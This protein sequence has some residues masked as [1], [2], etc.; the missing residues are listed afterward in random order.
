VKIRHKHLI[1]IADIE[2]SSGC[3]DYEMSSFM[4]RSWPEAC[5]AMSLDVDVLVNT[6]FDAGAESIIV[7]DFH[8]TGFNL[9]PELINSKARVVQGYQIGPV[10]G[11]GD[12]SPATGLIM[13]G[14]HA[15]SG[16]SGFLAHTL[17]S[18]ICRL[19]V[20]GELMSEAELFSASLAPWG[21]SPLFFS[22]CP[23]ACQHVL[24]KIPGIQCY[25]VDKTCDRSSLDT[26]NWRRS[27]AKTAADS[28]ENEN[29]TPF[30]P[31]GPFKA[32]VEMR[33]GKETAQRLAERWNYP[34]SES[35]ITLEAPDIHTLYQQLM[36]LCYLSPL[37]QKILPLGLSLFNLRGR[38][39]LAWVRSQLQKQNL[40]TG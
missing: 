15:P 25:P 16:S 32:I 8:R 2:G 7:K 21:L 38:F 17:T 9:L 24:R 13:V 1:I 34:V 20:N 11:I 12:P 33:D 4:T 14:M 10:P 3:R 23:V 28:L 5:H 30:L 19:E 39:G 40:F 6:L 22:G 29:S 27:M 18:R 31:E 37:I 36:Q 35:S 26:V